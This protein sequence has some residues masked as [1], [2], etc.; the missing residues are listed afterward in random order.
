MGRVKT[1]YMEE[2][3]KRDD[4]DYPD[5]Y[6][7]VPEGWKYVETSTEQEPHSEIIPF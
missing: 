5:E 4:D 7:E 6:Y 3:N 2:I 1:F